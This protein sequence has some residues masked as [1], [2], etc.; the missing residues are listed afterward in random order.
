MM[1]QSKERDEED[2]DYE[3]T[4][5][6]TGKEANDNED[7]NDKLFRGS[8]VPAGSYGIVIKVPG[9][10]GKWCLWIRELRSSS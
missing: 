3:D 8:D 9:E 6:D 5:Q 1:Y 7:R 10:K 4:K 2:R